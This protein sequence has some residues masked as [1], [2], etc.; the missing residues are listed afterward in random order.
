MIRNYK[1]LEQLLSKNYY[2]V[3]SNYSTRPVI[4]ILRL[5]LVSDF[6][7]QRLGGIKSGLS[8]SLAGLVMGVY[9][10]LRKGLDEY[11]NPRIVWEDW[12]RGE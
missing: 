1:E 2:P 8:L 9:T 3:Y 11:V 4:Q 12:G 6:K 10:L 5:G 7:P